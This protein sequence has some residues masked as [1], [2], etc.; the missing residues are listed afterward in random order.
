MAKSLQ[1]THP[2]SAL[3]MRSR[4]QKEVT[5]WSTSS[6]ERFLIIFGEKACISRISS[7]IYVAAY[8]FIKSN[9]SMIFLNEIKM[10]INNTRECHG[11][12]CPPSSYVLKANNDI[13]IKRQSTTT[14]SFELQ[15]SSGKFYIEID[16]F[17]MNSLF[18]FYNWEVCEDIS[19]KATT[20]DTGKSI[21]VTLEFVNNCDKEFIL[22]RNGFVAKL[23]IWRV[24]N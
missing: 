3:K 19:C 13:H 20:N 6:I 21:D 8:F 4:H 23:N 12:L 22:I 7:V 15:Y 16:E 11:L 9:I 5:I 17:S 10:E 24:V 2:N 14:T 18:E 1:L